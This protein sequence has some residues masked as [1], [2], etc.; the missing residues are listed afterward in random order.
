LQEV[1]IG[2]PGFISARPL[3]FGI[4]RRLVTE[5]ELK[6]DEPGKLVESLSRGDL[7]AALIP[8]IEY[9]RGTGKYFLKGPAIVA[10]PATGSVVLLA[11]KPVESIA[12]IAVN[13]FC[14]T[15]VCVARIVLSEKYGIT[16][17]LCVMKNDRG[18]WREDYDGIL[19]AGN[20]GLDFLVERPDPNL[21]VF[22]IS[23]MWYELTSLPL[24]LSLW[25]YNHKDLEGCLRKILVLSRNLG[26]QHLSRLADGIAQTTQYNNELLYNYLLNCWDYHL[27]DPAL[28]GLAVL[29]E[30]A[31]RYD[32]LQA[33]RLTNPVTK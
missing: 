16:P 5:A 20:K 7:D 14:R 4:T 23:E 13:E 28:E 21:T 24:A 31:I 11:N 10:R 1:R 12:R 29:E 26:M 25:V 8:S 3:I 22:N 17:D 19:L 2:V 30:F 18:E 27:T 33:A 6:Y 32:L 9:L 15:P